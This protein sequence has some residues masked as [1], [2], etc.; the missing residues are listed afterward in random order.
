MSS[1]MSMQWFPLCASPLLLTAYKV[2]YQVTSLNFLQS[3]ICL[4]LQIKSKYE[5]KVFS[6]FR[7]LANAS[8]N[9]TC[10][11]MKQ[12]NSFL[13]FIP[14]Y[15]TFYPHSLI[16][17]NSIG[18]LLLILVTSPVRWQSV[19]PMSCI[20]GKMPIL[21]FTLFHDTNAILCCGSNTLLLGE[22]LVCPFE[23]WALT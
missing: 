9:Y 17:I 23:K 20:P 2:F 15:C 12:T 21:F 14:N 10:E 11:V 22:S 13:L 19:M 3:F 5:G 1:R 8:S 18:V 16:C 4:S 6:C 7:N